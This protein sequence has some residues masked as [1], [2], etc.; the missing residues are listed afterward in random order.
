MGLLREL[1]RIPDYVADV[2]EDPQYMLRLVDRMKRQQKPSYG[3]IR[4]CATIVVA[5]ILGYLVIGALPHELWSETASTDNVISLI[6]IALVAPL[7]CA[8]G[9][10]YMQPSLVFYSQL[11]VSGFRCSF[12]RKHWTISRLIHTAFNSGV[13][14]CPTLLDAI[15][16]RLHYLT[17]FADCIC[18]I[19]TEMAT[20]AFWK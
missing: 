6:A 12:G 2:N 9:I 19:L 16:C 8:I 3:I 20:N 14:D 1:W 7:G 17:P 11:F 18:S 5:D 13:L 10:H 4:H 15:Q